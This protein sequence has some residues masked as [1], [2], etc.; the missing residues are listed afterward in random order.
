MTRYEA[1]SSSQQSCDEE[2]M[3]TS[4]DVKQSSKTSESNHEE[5]EPRD[6]QPDNTCMMNK[7]QAGYS[8]PPASRSSSPE[9]RT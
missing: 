7:Q 9:D 6:R 5:Y 1:G 8:V 3:D 2:M 4:G